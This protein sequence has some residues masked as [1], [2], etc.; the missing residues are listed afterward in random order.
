MGCPLLRGVRPLVLVL[1]VV[2]G[3]VGEI[4]ASN[5]E[6]GL[7]GGAATV[8]ASPLRRLTRFEYNATVRDLLGDTT[9]PADAFPPDEVRSGFDNNAG[10]LGVSPLQTEA[11]MNAAETLAKTAMLTPNKLL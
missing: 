9:N 2:P 11:Y 8:S 6:P 3:C 5:I 1:V 7:C 10:A 4:G